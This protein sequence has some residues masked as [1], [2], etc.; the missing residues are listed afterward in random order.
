MLIKDIILESFKDARRI[1]AKDVDQ[2]IVDEYLYLFKELKDNNIISQNDI[3]FWIKSGWINFK[4]YIDNERHK[5]LNTKKKQKSKK[6]ILHKSDGVLAIVPLTH[7]SSKYYGANTKWCTSSK[8]DSDWIEYFKK[9]ESI[10]IYVITKS[11]KFAIRADSFG[12]T[13]Y[14]SQDDEID[15]KTFKNSTGFDSDFFINK[16]Y[17]YIDIIRKYQNA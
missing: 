3:S 15:E 16:S 6:I 2:S 9:D 4:E 10:I 17:Q 11:E 8:S 12:S 14:N 1:F 13:L 5:L 7:E